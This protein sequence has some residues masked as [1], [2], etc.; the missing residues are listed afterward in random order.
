MLNKV[1]VALLA[2]IAMFLVVVAL[3]PSEFPVERTATMAAEPATVF[4]QVNDF[5]KWEAWSPW[6]SSIPAPR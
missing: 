6:G 3:Q 5:N 4:D 1:L 2:V